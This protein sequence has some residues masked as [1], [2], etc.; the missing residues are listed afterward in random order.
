MRNKIYK[1]KAHIFF[2][3]NE[4]YWTAGPHLGLSKNPAVRL[5]CPHNPLRTRDQPEDPE[6]KKKTKNK[7]KRI[8]LQVQCGPLQRILNN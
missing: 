3:Q 1:C 7:S 4:K 2:I 5:A 8:H 6:N